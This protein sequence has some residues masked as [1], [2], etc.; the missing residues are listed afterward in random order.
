MRPCPRFW[1]KV[2]EERPEA[3][4][5]AEGRTGSVGPVEVSTA[6]WSREREMSKSSEP[7]WR[8]RE[9]SDQRTMRELD[10]LI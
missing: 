8:E 2:E 6:E 4:E 9:P 10:C 7:T 5:E 1:S 3:P